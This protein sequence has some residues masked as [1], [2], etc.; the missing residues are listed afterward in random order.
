MVW[1]RAGFENAIA[2]KKQTTALQPNIICIA[3]VLKISSIFWRLNWRL[4]CYVY[5]QQLSI[6]S[7]GIDDY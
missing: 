7:A 4:A 5:N 6:F 2:R 1:Q 3:I